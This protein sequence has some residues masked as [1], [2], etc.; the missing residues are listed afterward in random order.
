ME[1]SL[2]DLHVWKDEN[3]D[4]GSMSC[5]DCPETNSNPPAKS[6]CPNFDGSFD[7]PV[8]TLPTEFANAVIGFVSSTKE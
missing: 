5:E 2:T 8:C 4:T 7:P 1:F 6:D 3:V